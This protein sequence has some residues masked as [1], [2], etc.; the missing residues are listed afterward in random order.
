MSYDPDGEQYAK[1][2]GHAHQDLAASL[3]KTLAAAHQSERALETLQDR[4]GPECTEDD[5]N[6]DLSEHL[7]QVLM[8]LRAAYR[9]IRT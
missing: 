2:L 4:K 9:A 8:H 5:L 3:E 6:Q 1:A 7:R